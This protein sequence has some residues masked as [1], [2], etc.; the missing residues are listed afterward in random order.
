[1]NVFSVS[2][3]IQHN[4]NTPLENAQ[5]AHV[6]IAPRKCANTPLTSL[7]KKL[8]AMANTSIYSAVLSLLPSRSRAYVGM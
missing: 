3:L 7:P 5:S 8:P 6:T 4:A 2:M 1:M